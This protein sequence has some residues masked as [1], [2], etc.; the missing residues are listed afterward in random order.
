MNNRERA[1]LPYQDLPNSRSLTRVFFFRELLSDGTCIFEAEDGSTMLVETMLDLIA[2]EVKQRSYDM[3]CQCDMVGNGHKLL[4]IRI[5]T[6][7]L[8]TASLE[9]MP[10]A[11]SE[12]ETAD[13]LQDE[14]LMSALRQG[15][16]EAAQGQGSAWPN[17]KQR[18][19]QEKELRG[20]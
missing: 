13:I 5:E 7:P 2:E 17:V 6:A 15:Q 19:T 18:L 4:R 11:T 8:P 3:A 20:K 14:E 16:R 9:P 1:R 10:E 12:Q